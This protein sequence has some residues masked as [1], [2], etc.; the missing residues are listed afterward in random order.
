MCGG[1]GGSLGGCSVD[2]CMC[3]GV[4]VCS[5]CVYSVGL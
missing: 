2:V 4:C 3:G 5:V 1:A